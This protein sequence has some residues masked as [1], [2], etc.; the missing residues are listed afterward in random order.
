[1]QNYLFRCA[2]YVFMDEIYVSANSTFDDPV[3]ERFRNAYEVLKDVVK[4]KVVEGVDSNT[5]SST[6]VVDTQAVDKKVV[7][8]QTIDNLVLSMRESI[9]IIAKNMAEYGSRINSLHLPFRVNQNISELIANDMYSAVD[10]IAN[11]PQRY[12][13]G[14]EKINQVLS[15]YVMLKNILENKDVVSGIIDKPL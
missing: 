1:M 4:N 9:D 2:F 10:H 6:Q 5:G 12:D 13:S 11:Y 15:T 8:K 14:V 3:Y 7:D